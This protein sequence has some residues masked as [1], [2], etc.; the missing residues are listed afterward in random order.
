MKNQLQY[1]KI[2]LR[3]LEPEDIELLYQW[4]NNMKIWE[5]SN[6]KTP[7][8]KYILAQYI[9]ESAGGIYN[10]KQLRLIIQDE[11]QQPVGAIDL[12]DF[13]PYHL[14]AGVGI[15]IHEKENKNKGYASDALEILSDYGLNTLG[16]KQMY[17]NIAADNLFSI[18]LFEK[19]GFI[20]IGVKK[21][22]IKTSDG[23]KDEILF[24]KMLC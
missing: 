13:E 21:N 7:Y 5:I 6:T 14:R 12:F 3:P 10:T 22:W 24:Q 20:K 11:N 18:K 9:K 15:L 23:W 4:E 8:S 17:A 2:S 16:L 1:G 19:S